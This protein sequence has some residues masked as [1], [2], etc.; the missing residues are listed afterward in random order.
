MNKFQLNQIAKATGPNLRSTQTKL[1]VG[2]LDRVFSVDH[3][4]YINLFIWTYSLK[5]IN[6]QSLAIFL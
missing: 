4:S 3:F 6:I 1:K 2:N 5:D